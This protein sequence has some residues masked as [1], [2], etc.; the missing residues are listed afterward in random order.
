MSPLTEY[1]RKEIIRLLSLGQPLPE[2]WR[3]RLFPGGQRTQE[4]GKEYRLVYDGNL[5][6]EE[7]LAQTPAAPWLVGYFNLSG[8]PSANYLRV[9]VPSGRG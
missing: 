5:K 4:T 9:T 3:K 2:H 8:K 1:E 7:V 6:R